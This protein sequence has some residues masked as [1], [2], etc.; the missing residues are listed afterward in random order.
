MIIKRTLIRCDACKRTVEAPDDIE[1]LGIRP[2]VPGFEHLDGWIT[3]Q[4][5]HHLCP[6]CARPYLAK[7]AEME[8]ELKRLAGIETL[9]LDL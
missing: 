1:T 6:S 5:T 2:H 7:K 9:E 3:T 4:G 8:R